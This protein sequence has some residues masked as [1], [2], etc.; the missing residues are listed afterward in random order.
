[1]SAFIS[2]NRKFVI[3]LTAIIV[4]TVLGLTGSMFVSTAY[5]E[6][7]GASGTSDNCTGGGSGGICTPDC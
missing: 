5:A 3:V 6:D 7:G 2:K 4:A 1:M